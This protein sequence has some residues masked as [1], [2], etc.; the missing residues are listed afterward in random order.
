MDLAN[1]G[2]NVIL[3]E[4]SAEMYGGTCINVG[5]IPS[6]ILITQGEK[7]ESFSDAMNFKNTLVN[8]L[9][10]K[11]F[12]KLDSHENITILTGKVKFISENSVKVEL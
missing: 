12:E 10:G 9:R 11:N 2:E 4:K 5:C 3:V 6:K 8:A 1:R 7:G